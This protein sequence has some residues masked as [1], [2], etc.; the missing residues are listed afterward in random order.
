MTS[1]NDATALGLTRTLPEVNLAEVNSRIMDLAKAQ[2]ADITSDVASAGIT[3]IHGSGRLNP[4]HTVSVNDLTLAGD[5]ILLATGSRP[6]TITDAMPDGD[7]I[8]SW[9]QL[10]TLKELPA[11][12]IVIGSGI[13]GAEFA[14]AYLGL[15][16]H[17]TLISSRAQVLPGNDSDAAD[18]IEDIFRQRGGVIIANSRAMSATRASD[19]VSVTLTDG[20]IIHGSHVLV[21]V[22]SIPNT[23][24][25]GLTE[26]GITVN[27]HG[28]VE[29]DRVSRTNVP[30]IYAAGD[31]TGVLP[32]ASVAAMQGRIAMQ[33]ALGDSVIPID[34]NLV[35]STIFTSPEIASV[36]VCATGDGVEMVKLSL[37]T[38]AR[39]KM[40]NLTDGF[41][42][43]FARNSI[44]VGGVICAP[45][46]SE[47]IYPIT[48][49]ISSHLSVDSFAQAFT[50]YPSLTGSISEVARRLHARN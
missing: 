20:K 16:S 30:G 12:L 9:D 40:E 14:F 26:A 2:S 42:K 5:V 18:V 50:V 25:L 17:V 8:L 46:A 13:T 27:D 32:L 23:E 48:L 7:R 3:V 22:G 31:C 24:N 11:H 37:A 35:S 39:A 36:G 44:L 43:L 45:R 21:T 28:Y 4:D 1:T 33:H 29:V 15:G 19:G 10:Y 6:R 49:G 34:I 41:V 47:L 38:N